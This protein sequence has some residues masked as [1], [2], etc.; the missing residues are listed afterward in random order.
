MGSLAPS[1]R[2]PQQPQSRRRRRRCVV[3]VVS[4]GLFQ[5]PF[6]D[7]DVIFCSR[8]AQLTLD[9]L[10][11][12]ATAAAP[13]TIRR[14]QS[15][16]PPDPP[17]RQR[18][19]RPSKASR[20][21]SPRRQRTGSSSA[22]SIARGRAGRCGA[23]SC[24][25]RAPVHRFGGTR[26]PVELAGHQKYGVFSC[27]ER[28]VVIVINARQRHVLSLASSALPFARVGL[29]CYGTSTAKSTPLSSFQESPSRLRCD[30][31]A[32][33]GSAVNAG[34]RPYTRIFRRRFRT[35]S[36]FFPQP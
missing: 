15:V 6:I 34:T 20:D 18:R 2:H 29:E 3:V 7:A 8:S 13:R 25:S 24:R 21:R 35:G 36:S 22:S 1:G 27:F 5:L 16:G 30:A 19:P 28:L 9:S 14:E 33:E 17:T 4:F 26:R 10:H 31:A 32:G 23:L 11:D 12:L